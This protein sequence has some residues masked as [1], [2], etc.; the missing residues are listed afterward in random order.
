MTKLITG[1]DVTVNVIMCVATGYTGKNCEVKLHQCDT[2]S[3]ENNALCLIED[4]VTV[5]YCV[6]DYHGD[7]CQFQYDECQLGPR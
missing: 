1:E 4:G 2:V 7:R 6:P 5:C 3:C